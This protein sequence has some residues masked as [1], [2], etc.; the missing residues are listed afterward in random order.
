MIKYI[1]AATTII[2][3]IAS[4]LVGDLEFADTIHLIVTA[5]LGSSIRHGIKTGAYKITQRLVCMFLMQ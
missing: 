3:A 1:V 2:G 5:L 4:H